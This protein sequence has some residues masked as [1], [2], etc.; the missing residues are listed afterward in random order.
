[1]DD[2]LTLRDAVQ[3]LI[4]RKIISVD[5]QEATPAHTPALALAHPSVAGPFSSEPAGFEDVGTSG[6]FALTPVFSESSSTPIDPF[7]PISA[8]SFTHFS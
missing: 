6:V 7:D 3:R 5:A 2:Y 4:D 8:I 1:M